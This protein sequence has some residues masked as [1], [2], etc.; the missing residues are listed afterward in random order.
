M[1]LPKEEFDRL[2]QQIPDSEKK[3][4]LDYMEYLAERAAKKAWNEIEEVDESLTEEEKREL[5]KA[6]EDDEWISLEDLK[7]ELNL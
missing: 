5:A 1:A 7:R 2:F 4:L 3:S 6:K